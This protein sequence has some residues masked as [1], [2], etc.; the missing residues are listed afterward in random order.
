MLLLVFPDHQYLIHVIDDDDDDDDCD[1]D[2]DG[3]DD[4]D[5]DED[6]DDND[7]DDEEEDD[8]EDEDEDDDDDEE[9]DDDDE[10]RFDQSI[11]SFATQCLWY[12]GSSVPV[13]RPQK[14]A[15]GAGHKEYKSSAPIVVTTKRADLL[16]L[17]AWAIDRPETGTPWDANAS[18]LCRRL[19][20]YHVTKRVPKPVSAL[21]TCPH[22]FA[23]FL[24]ASTAP[25]SS[26]GTAAGDLSRGAI[27]L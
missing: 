18:M 5:D 24:L 3:D 12:D 20:V 8:D 16:N 15:G 9:E 13:A 23:D 4:D 1:D 21:Q 27:F 25:A 6:D 2:D 10:W 11:L 26:S 19:K 17:E 14:D 7:D 22:C